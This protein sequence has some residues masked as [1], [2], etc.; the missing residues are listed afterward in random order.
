MADAERGEIGHQCLG[1]REGEALVELQPVGGA[2]LGVHAGA[3]LHTAAAKGPSASRPSVSCVTAPMLAATGMPAMPVGGSS[4]AGCVP[5]FSA[6]TSVPAAKR[7]AMRSASSVR[8]T[9]LP[10]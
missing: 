10:R 3:R 2:K 5:A 4:L 6:I 7:Q 9:S 8:P 1:I